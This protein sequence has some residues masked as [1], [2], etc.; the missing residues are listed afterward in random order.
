[1]LVVRFASKHMHS[2]STTEIFTLREKNGVPTKFQKIDVCREKRTIYVFRVA[3][4]LVKGKVGRLFVLF[5]DRFVRV[6][7]LSRFLCSFL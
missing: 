2:F 7:Y 5:L 6:S 4:S 3:D 1:M